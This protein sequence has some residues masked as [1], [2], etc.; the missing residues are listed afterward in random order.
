MDSKSTMYIKIIN[1]KADRNTDKLASSTALGGVSDLGKLLSQLRNKI[2]IRLWSI[3]MT[4]SNRH[5]FI[6]EWTSTY[7]PGSISRA[8]FALDVFCILARIA[9]RH[10]FCLSICFPSQPCPAGPVYHRRDDTFEALHW[11]ANFTA[12]GHRRK[13]NR[14]YTLRSMQN[15]PQKGTPS[16][17]IATDL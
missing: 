12:I 14:S 6:L 1:R 17:L 13:A 11:G 3:G 8:T 7:R 16:Y 10:R 4:L 15:T 5:E 9:F 2:R